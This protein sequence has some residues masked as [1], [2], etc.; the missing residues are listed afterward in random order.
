MLQKAG[1]RLF[2]ED[3]VFGAHGRA[4]N[5][6]AR[7]TENITEQGRLMRQDPE[8][9]RTFIRAANREQDY[10]RLFGNEF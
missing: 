4:H 8:L 5:P 1:E 10:P 6:F 2:G 7:P 3:R 9:A